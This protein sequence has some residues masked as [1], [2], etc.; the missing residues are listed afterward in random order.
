MSDI[1]Q[2]NSIVDQCKRAIAYFT[3][4]A[5]T[6]G[7]NEIERVKA[8]KSIKFWVAE[9]EKARIVYTGLIFKP[10]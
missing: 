9:L 4:A 10:G 8:E 3:A 7:I 2:Y 1:K 5:N 6:E